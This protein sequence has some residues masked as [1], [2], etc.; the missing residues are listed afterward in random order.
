MNVIA[1]DSAYS[2]YPWATFV[3]RLNLQLLAKDH[4][5]RNRL[6][7]EKYEAR[8]WHTQLAPN[9]IDSNRNQQRAFTDGA[10]W[11]DDQYSW[12]IRI[13]TQG[14]DPPPLR[15]PLSPRPERDLV[16][17]TNWALQPYGVP[18]MSYKIVQANWL[19]RTYVLL[20]D[21]VISTL[22][23]D[24]WHLSVAEDAKIKSFSQILEARGEQETAYWKRKLWEMRIW[25]VSRRISYHGISTKIQSLGPVPT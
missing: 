19:A 16:Y 5:P 20:D 25:Y 2:A 17:C 15:T 21:A 8:G 24:C 6:A 14:V 9:P 7:V 13:S 1:Y 18:Y 3:E 22:R 11:L 10:R 23:E 4:K 12:T